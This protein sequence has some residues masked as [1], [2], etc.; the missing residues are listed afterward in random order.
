MHRR[1]AGHRRDLR[2]PIKGSGPI[3][4]EA[5]A[6]LER[7]H[8]VNGVVAF[9][10]AATGPVAIILAVG[11]RGGLAPADI[12]SW[13]FGSFFLNGLISLFF[14]L[15]Y[16]QPLVFFWTIPGAVLVGPALTHL[17]FAEV[18][19]A[20]YATGL[21]ML[22]LG[23]SG[24]IRRAMQAAPMPIVMAMVAG[25]F[26]R[27]GLDL[28]FSMRDEFWI[29]A[30]MIAVFLAL[31]ALPSLGARMPPLIGALAIGAVMIAVLGKFV[32]PPGESLQIVRPNFYAPAFSWQAMVELVVPL[33]I[34]VLVV[35]NGQGITVLRAAGHEP[36][37]NAITMAC[38]I[39]AM[40]SAVVGAVSTCLTGP[41]NAIISAS[42][43]RSGQYSAGVIVGLLALVFGLLAPVFTHLL[44]AT[45]KAFIAVLGGLA[46]LRVLQNA[47]V[48]SFR[49]KFTLGALVTFLVTVAD[50][51]IWNVGAPFWGLVFGIA[52][53]M[54]LE[55][56]DFRPLGSS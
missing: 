7:E 8:L 43:A 2:A 49:E 15:R 50:V 51:P 42:G 36:P 39:G 25:V 28:V 54:L 31:T 10:F 13:I 17:S 5:L 37:V 1:R 52:I 26:L 35:Q 27:F 12:A 6:D 9:I 44:L 4:R 53:S 11:T 48:V 16:R 19:G 38:G 23:W 56:R 47:F 22:A 14:C 30:P 40:A 21:L 3:F 32:A 20:Y 34:T 55:R 41:V 46:M 33:A 18:I 24:W 45:P 29:A